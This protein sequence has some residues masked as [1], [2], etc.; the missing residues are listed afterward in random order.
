MERGDRH[1][2]HHRRGQGAPARRRGL[3]RG[4]RRGRRGSRRMRWIS[5]GSTRKRCA[6]AGAI[7][8]AD[9][10]PLVVEAMDADPA[11]AAAITGAYDHVL[12]DEYQ[13][14]NPGPGPAA[15][16]LRQAPGCSLWVV[17]DDDQT[18]YAFRAADVRFIL[19]FPRKYRRA[20]V[21]VLDRNYRSASQIVAAA[22]RLI[23]NNRARRDKNSGRSSPDAGEIVIRGYRA[24]EIEARQVARAVAR[25]HQ[26][27]PRATGDRRPLSRG[28][29]RSRAPAGSA[30]ARHSLRGARRRRPVARRGR[31]AGGRVAR[32]SARRQHRSRP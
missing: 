22:E 4:D 7:D 23:A 21:H 30:G 16:S 17:G 2:G 14:V 25:L 3:R 24:P 27:R 11:Y 20:Q 8:F 5:S 28:L 10:V 31:Q 18:L 12:V 13:D 9:M 29:G 15:R 32:L 1:P 6:S 26:A 19:D